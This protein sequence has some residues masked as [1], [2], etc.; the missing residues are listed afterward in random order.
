[1]TDTETE[2]TTTPSSNFLMDTD[3][4]CR[5]WANHIGVGTKTGKD[6]WRRFVLNIYKRFTDE[7][8]E[9]QKNHA[10]MSVQDPKWKEWNDEQKYNLLNKKAYAKC[11]SIQRKL[12][13]KEDFHIDLPDGYK[14]RNNT[15]N[16][17]VSTKEMMDIFKQ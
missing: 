13:T 7:S 14:E 10:Y 17:R 2:A 9:G 8:T 5:I 4:Y 6:D 3:T 12:K 1:M 15:A 16:S 11:I